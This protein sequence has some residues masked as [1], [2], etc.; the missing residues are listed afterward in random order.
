[1]TGV[2]IFDNIDYMVTVEISKQIEKRISQLLKE[3]SLSLNDIDMINIWIHAYEQYGLDGYFESGFDEAFNDHELKGDRQGQ[4]SA[5][6]NKQARIIYEIRKTKL[7]V[8]VIK[9]TPDHDY[10]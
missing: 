3:G 8:K 6:I 9:V 5:S 7:V 10:S 2:I 4:R 1:L